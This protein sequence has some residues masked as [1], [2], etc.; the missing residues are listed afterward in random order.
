MAEWKANLNL[1]IKEWHWMMVFATILLVF[2]IRLRFLLGFAMLL[3]VVGM[4]VGIFTEM[5]DFKKGK[6]HK[7]SMWQK[8]VDFLE[9]EDE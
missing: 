7:K 5:K 2:A 4:L 6:P 3:Y 8:F 9:E 1:K